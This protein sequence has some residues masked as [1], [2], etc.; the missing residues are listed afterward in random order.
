MIIGGDFIPHDPV[1]YVAAL[2]A[3][4]GDKDGP[5][6]WDF[7]LAPL[8]A[9]LRRADIAV[10]NLET[11]LTN[12]PKAVT[13]EMLFNGLPSMARGLKARGVTVATFANNHCLDQHP[14]GI[15]ETRKWLADTGLL[16]AGCD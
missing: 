5:Q 13:A 3:A 6:G 11:P 14:E 15:V 7:L 8:E 1:K 4:K 16:T 9:D 2:N 12:D 10:V